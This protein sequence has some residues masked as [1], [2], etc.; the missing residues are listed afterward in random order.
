MPLLVSNF[1]IIQVCSDFTRHAFQTRKQRE[2]SRAIVIAGNAEHRGTRRLVASNIHCIR[3]PDTGKPASIWRK[4]RYSNLWAHTILRS[5]PHRAP[6]ALASLGIRGGTN[7]RNAKPGCLERCSCLR[8][9][10]VRPGRFIILI[11]PPSHFSHLRHPPSALARCTRAGLETT[12]GRLPY[13]G[14]LM[15]D[16][17]NQLRVVSSNFTA[18]TFRTVQ[19]RGQGPRRAY[20]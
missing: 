10:T 9:R 14:W 1:L 5:A 16:P 13:I 7:A 3:A 4:R 6:R 19:N 20:R 8:T 15:E 17:Q 12:R 11:Q 18:C 2:R